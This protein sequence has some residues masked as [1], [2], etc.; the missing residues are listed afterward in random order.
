MPYI[1]LFLAIF[2]EVFATGLLKSSQGFSK[3]IPT[4]L[5]FL[6][7]SASFFFLSLTVKYFKIAIVYAIWA[8]LGLFFITIFAA[9]YY[10]EIPNLLVILGMLLI[11]VGVII[12]YIFK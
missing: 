2:F 9:I 11:I 12:I 3:L 1:Y 10:K 7:Y 6:S 8:G 5:V 4:I